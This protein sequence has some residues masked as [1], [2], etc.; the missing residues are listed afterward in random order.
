MK[1][2]QVRNWTST[3]NYETKTLSILL[4]GIK[5]IE[6]TDIELETQYSKA[7]NLV[8]RFYMLRDINII[9]IKYAEYIKIVG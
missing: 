4:N 2:E 9:E 6:I 8:D 5:F 7:F 1:K 3:P